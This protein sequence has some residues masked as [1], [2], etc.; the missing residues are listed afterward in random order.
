VQD[1][2]CQPA[3]LDAWT[4]LSVIAGRTERVR[5]FPNVANLPLRPPAVLARSA[6]S[7]DLLTGGRA[8]LGLGA[9][10]FSGRDRRQWRPPARAGAGGAR[11]GRG[12]RHRSRH[13]G[14]AGSI[15]VYG[16][17]YRVVGA[18]PG[19]VPAHDIGI[20]IGAYKPRMLRLVG[21]LAD[22][23]LPSLGTP[24]STSS[25]G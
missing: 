19:P 9:G 17:E 16:E 2:P 13:L 14:R 12:D 8:E 15:K 24:E 11:P 3:F 18:K 1:D 7:L 6:A 21:R 25:P 22:G 20:W 5:L 23:W 4:L 10:A